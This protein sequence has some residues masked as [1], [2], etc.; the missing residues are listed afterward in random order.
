MAVKVFSHY[1]MCNKSHLKTVNYVE[2]FL[3]YL[4]VNA[5]PEYY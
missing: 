3:S 2:F 4:D 5:D 1:R